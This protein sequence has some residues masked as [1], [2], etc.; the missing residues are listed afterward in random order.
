[1]AY[2][3]NTDLPSRVKGHI[4]DHAQSISREAFNHPLQ[5]YHNDE[6]RAFRVAWSAVE[7]GYE[8]CDDGG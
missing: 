1:M 8:K 4:P 7:R 5:E 3:S 6:E 2:Q